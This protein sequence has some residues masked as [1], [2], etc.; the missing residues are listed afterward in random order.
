MRVEGYQGSQIAHLR[1]DGGGGG[2]GRGVGE[3][4][5]EP[6]G[7]LLLPRQHLRWFLFSRTEEWQRGEGGQGKVFVWLVATSRVDARPLAQHEGRPARL[8]QIKAEYSIFH[9]KKKSIAF[10]TGLDKF[11]Y[12]SSMFTDI[13]FYMSAYNLVF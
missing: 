1:L 9:C 7:H 12:L 8:N 2:G 11:D 6:V 5:G 4:A 13:F 10:P 3:E